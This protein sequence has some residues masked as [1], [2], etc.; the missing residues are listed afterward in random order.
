MK[1]SE[2]YVHFKKIYPECSIKEIKNLIEA[3]KGDKYWRVFPNH[4][5][6]IYVVAL[7]RAKIP[8]LNGYQA[9]ATYLKKV[10]VSPQSAIFSRKGRILLTF[11]KG[12]NYK[13]KCVIT[14]PAFLKLMNEDPG[15]I[16]EKFS[17]GKFPPF[18]NSKNLLIFIHSNNES[19]KK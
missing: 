6:A 9:K 4:R 10:I 19:L 1:T 13:A 3:I 15:S 5:D 18:V 14:W 16:Y 8:L 12:S 11:K 17:K 2:L 7:S